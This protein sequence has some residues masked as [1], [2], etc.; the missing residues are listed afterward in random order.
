[1]ARHPCAAVVSSSSLGSRTSQVIEGVLTATRKRKE[2]NG[3]KVLLIVGVEAR[4]RT[5][6]SE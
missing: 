2:V 6:S 5:Q 4:W 1:M 3:L